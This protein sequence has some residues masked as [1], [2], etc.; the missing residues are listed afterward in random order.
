MA[1]PSL[2]DRMLGWRD[3]WL[4][5]ERFQNWA[6]RFPLTRPIAR[7]NAKT[8]FD[9]CA[10]FV[11]S[12]VLLAC[13]ELQLFDELADTQLGVEALAT[14][15][16]MPVAS[17]RL[18][19]DAAVA[20]LLLQRRGGDRYGLG[21]LGAALRGNPGVIA[22]IRHHALFYD[23]LRDPVALLRGAPG[24]GRLAQY[25]PYAGAALPADLPEEETAAYTKLMAQS[26]PMVARV[27]L[28]A[29][30]FG[31]HRCLLDLGGGDGAFLSAVVQRYPH[32]RG[33]LFDLPAVA[34]QARLRFR[35]AGLSERVTAYGGSFLVDDLPG[36][37][38]IITLIR[39]L[40]DHN[41]D[42]A[43]ALLR[44]AYRALPRGGALVIA[45]P[46]VGAA[47]AAAVGDAYFAFYLHAMGSGR[48]RRI[49]ELRA[50]LIEAGFGAIRLTPGDVPLLA[51]VIF[52]VKT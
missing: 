3:R 20:L 29:H 13:V 9:L 24:G 4:S 2:R 16:A 26:Q 42:A 18:L 32:L 7:R 27:V 40:H 35:D 33:L 47:G 6:A 5:D 14:R 28:A 41:D 36:G 22:M 8:L 46:L 44:A 38:D 52:A 23:D 49:G 30:S 19:L 21:P 17:M 37:A 10:G 25:W 50:M 1:A 43:M 39:I 51:S 31:R 48:P 11:Y 45:E 12:Q 15:M 34:A